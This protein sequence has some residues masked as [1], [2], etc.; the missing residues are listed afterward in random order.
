MPLN[1]IDFLRTTNVV[2]LMRAKENDK[3]DLKLVKTSLLQ[4]VV[5]CVENSNIRISSTRF[6]DRLYSFYKKPFKTYK[7]EFIVISGI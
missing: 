1:E 4:K 3:G 5:V 7:T 2:P 6:A